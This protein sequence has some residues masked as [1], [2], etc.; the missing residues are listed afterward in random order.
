M[1]S[2][3]FPRSVRK[4]RKRVMYHYVVVCIICWIP[5]IIFYTLEIFGFHSAFLEVFSRVCLYTT[6]FFNCL[7]FGMQDPHISRS[8]KR[9][10]QIIGLGCLVGVSNDTNLRRNRVEKTVMFENAEKTNA[11]ITKDKKTVYRY[12]RLS[13]EDKAELYRSRPDLNTKGRDSLSSNDSNDT[14]SSNSSSFHE[15]LLLRHAVTQ[16]ERER[17]LQAQAKRDHVNQ[18]SDTMSIDSAD[19][20]SKKYRALKNID[21]KIIKK[22]DLTDSR[23]PYYDSDSLIDNYSAGSSNSGTSSYSGP[24]EFI[25]NT[26]TAKNLLQSSPGSQID[27]DLE[28][29]LSPGNFN[30]IFFFLL[31]FKLILLLYSFTNPSIIR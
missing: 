6:G 23:N 22:P 21:G 27:P 12:H 20:T 26:T 18:L 14:N 16:M 5:T 29:S 31:I 4:R 3:A 7:V 11:D 28:S 13:K 25:N 19:L 9:A 1:S 8:F 24:N 17:S 10:F 30:L 15:P 2:R